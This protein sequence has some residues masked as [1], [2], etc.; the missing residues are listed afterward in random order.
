M[1]YCFMVR[2]SRSSSW[3]LRRI[4]RWSSTSF[5][6]CCRVSAASAALGASAADLDDRHGERV[7]AQGTLQQPKLNSQKYTTKFVKP[8]C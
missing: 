4:T 8:K 3:G 6:V 2:H 1:V 7:C 5:S